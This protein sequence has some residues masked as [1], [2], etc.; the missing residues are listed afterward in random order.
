M[1]LNNLKKS[2]TKMDDWSALA[3]IRERRSQR[4]TSV[5]RPRP[6]KKKIDKVKR[7]RELIS[8]LSQAEI[9]QLLEELDK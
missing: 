5:D 2:I 7:L 8:S 9:R 1:R 6:V 3:L 4:F